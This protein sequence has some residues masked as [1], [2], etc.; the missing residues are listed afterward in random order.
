[1]SDE[2]P[3]S[4][5]ATPYGV[6]PSPITAELVY[7]EA[8]GL[9]E[10]TIDGDDVY[11]LELRPSEG[12]LQV[13][14][15]RGA[16]GST[17]DVTPQGTNVRTRVHEYG[18]GSY[19][20]RGGAVWFTD[21]GDQRLYRIDPDGSEPRPIT[22]EPPGPAAWR[23]ADMDL[24]PDDAWVVCV[25]E[26]HHGETAEEVE[27]EIVAIP[28]DGQ[29]AARTLVSG[30]DFFASPRVSP[31]GGSLAYVAWDHPNMPWDETEVAVVDLGTDFEAGDPTR[32]AGGSGGAESVIAPVWSPWGELHVISDRTG[33][34]N[35]YRWDA[36]SDA[37]GDRL[38]PVV[39]V[40][41]ELGQPMWQLGQALYGFLH[42]GRVAVIATRQAVE[43]PS[44]LDPVAGTIQALGTDHTAL[45]SL[46]TDGRR[47]VFAGASPERPQ[48][49]VRIDA[50][51]G[52][53]SEVLARSREIPVDP[54]WLSRGE[55]ISFPTSRREEAHAFLYRPRN[56]DVTPPAGERP[57][58]I[59]TS[60]G[61]PTS[62]V[63][64]ALNLA[65]QFWT[66][67]GFAVV[68]VNYRGSTG[69]GRAYRQALYGEWGL[70]DVDDCTAAA[71][72]LVERGEVDPDR[73]AIRGGSAS[74]YTTLCALVFHDVFSAGASYY[75][76]ADLALL[77]EETHK[78]EARYLDQ[79][80]GPYPE[81]EET[82][83]ARSPIHHADQLERPV[84]LLQGL[85]DRVVPP[86]QAETMVEAMDRNATPHCYV[87]FPDEDHG[88]RDAASLVRSLEAELSFYA[89]VFGFEPADDLEDVEVRHLPGG[90][91]GV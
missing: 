47:V 35:L 59:V 58:L 49:I 71:R 18:G 70:L 26:V 56:P 8:R 22:P 13:L 40:E 78:F 12:G 21:F 16:D 65:V 69:Y 72:Y 79:L 48:E 9:H 62:H 33:W 45:R 38:T 7:A 11:W 28:A 32:I 66:S 4:E 60:H 88:F 20:V 30:R 67:R 10:V 81:A 1:M 6:W 42:D 57:P 14:V 43:T 90:P 46:A 86:S 39:Q 34:W 44:V 74:G 36:P 68:D 27:N 55:T 23:Y 50:T 15:R 89:Q 24:T 25:R 87:T 3:T 84:I 54:S 64:P 5:G 19:L 76:V 80:V 61:G 77:V 2:A 31:D 91:A 52:G 73:L 29:G 82:Y 41:A 63:A 37:A 75:G 85:E 17:T 53:D 83:R 51:G